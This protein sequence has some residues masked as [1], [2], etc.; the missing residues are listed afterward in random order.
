M[1]VHRERLLIGIFVAALTGHTPA[2]QA[3]V[4]EMDTHINAAKAAAGLDYAPRS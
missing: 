3:S 2:A 4:S 1:Y